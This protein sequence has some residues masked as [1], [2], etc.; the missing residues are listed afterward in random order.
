M[1]SPTPPDR[2]PRLPPSTFSAE[3][4]TEKALKK[5]FGQAV[6]GWLAASRAAVLSGGRVPDLSMMHTSAQFVTDAVR[7]AG[8]TLRETWLKAFARTGLDMRGSVDAYLMGLPYRLDGLS[9][10]ANRRAA[11]ALAEKV[12][13]GDVEVMRQAVA[14]ALDS[15]EY[16][17]YVNRLSQSEAAISVNAAR[18]D[19]AAI[20]W[21][22]GARI[23]KVWTSRRD[24]AVRHTHKKAHGQKV[25][26][27]A[28]FWVGGHP[29]FHPG[30]PTAPISETANCRCRATY[31]I[32]GQQ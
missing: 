25:P 2:T 27:T 14:D 28:P 18:H 29:M 1:T 20:A 24:D 3:D 13:S 15:A 7:R 12:G 6:A 8:A 30:D 21:R 26:F 5:T 23:E 11:R 4:E 16:D 32:G 17:G 22:A 31:V 19:V 10:L 9:T